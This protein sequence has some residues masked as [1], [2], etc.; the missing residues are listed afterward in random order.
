MFM[1]PATTGGVVSNGISPAFWSD[2]IAAF[3]DATNGNVE[4]YRL[5]GKKT[6]D[7]GVEY[8]TAK[9]IAKVVINDGGCCANAIWYS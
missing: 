7:N 9:S 2:E 6:G 5:D 3:T 1:I 4:I 8:S